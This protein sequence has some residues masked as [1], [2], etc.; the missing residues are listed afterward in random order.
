MSKLIKCDILSIALIL[1]L[2]AFGTCAVVFA[3]FDLSSKGK[4]VF[5]IL[6]VTSFFSSMSLIL[7]LREKRKSES[8]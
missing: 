3:T 6:L 2:I 8:K 7:Q 5:F 4:M 1:S